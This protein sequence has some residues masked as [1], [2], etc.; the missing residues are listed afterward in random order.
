MLNPNNTHFDLDYLGGPGVT[1][2]P[3]VEGEVAKVTVQSYVTNYNN[4]DINVDIF[5]A[6]GNVVF[7]KRS[8]ELVCEFEIKNPHLWNGVKDPYLYRAE[9]SIVKDSFILDNKEVTYEELQEKF[10]NL[11]IGYDWEDY[12]ELSEVKADGTLVFETDRMSYIGG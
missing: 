9:V 8:K 10:N 7:S 3:I 5:D 2:T 11:E 4:E 6:A 1:V 12:I